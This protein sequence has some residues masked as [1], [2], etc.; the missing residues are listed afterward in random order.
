MSL[1]R[2][3]RFRTSPR[4]HRRAVG[5]WVAAVALLLAACTG[6]AGEEVPSA[7]SSEATATDSGA[8]ETA[9]SGAP[10]SA[11]VLPQ[12]ELLAA[13]PTDLV[14]G[15][16]V[17]GGG[18]HVDTPLGT[19]SPLADETYAR[20][21]AANFSSVTPENQLK[22][23][24]VHP[25]RDRYDF[26]VADEIVEFAEANGQVVRGH[27]LLWHS[28]NPSWLTAG[29]FSDD[30]LREV[31]R[32]H[33]T[34]VVG[35]YA[36]RVA[37]WDVA[38]EIFGDDAALRTRENPFLARFG[39]DIVADAFRWAHEADPDALLFLNDYAIE[40]GGPKADA[41]L[42]LAEE[43]LAD[44]VPLHGMGFQGHLSTQYA[45]PGGMAENLARFAAL[46]LEVAVTEA[47]VRIPVDDDGVASAD[48]LAV[49]ADYFRV[50]VD[51]CL[52]VE[53]CRS[54]TVWGLSDAFSWVPFF[55][56]G[57]GAATLLDEELGIKPSYTAV[58][59]EL[60]AG[61]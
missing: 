23:E 55:F 61:R 60:A 59:E 34:T 3:S 15:M 13:A 53:T 26:E 37:Q 16:A 18:H 30:E 11:P 17:A 43:L 50:M 41:Y 54:F 14:I 2:N 6:P 8:G 28:Q 57:E 12:G 33:I 44:G 4:L 56:A 5:A 27:A 20:L 58:A 48:D 9:P 25:E 51:A 29:S 46:G 22:W 38:N 49:Q 32:E 10:S 31:L 19:G 1:R 7:T 52:V 45:K 36:G 35:R 21:L 42:A 24:W 39:I 40:G 47:D